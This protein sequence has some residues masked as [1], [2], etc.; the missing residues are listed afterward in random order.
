MEGARR[1]VAQPPGEI[2]G[3]SAM[4]PI[5]RR[6]AIA[7]VMALASV[8]LSAQPAAALHFGAIAE[9]GTLGTLTLT[10][11]ENADGFS[12]PPVNSVLTFEEGGR[13]NNLRVYRDGQLIWDPATVGMAR[14]N[15][16]EVT[17]SFT[18]ANG[19]ELVVTGIYTGP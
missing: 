12:S 7:A 2:E 17:C 14:N 10:G 11:T 19:V 6:R 3:R 1:R 16:E 4:G 15:L 5:R 18:L 8:A 9:C 13:L